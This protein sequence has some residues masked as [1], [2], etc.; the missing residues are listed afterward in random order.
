M[1]TTSNVKVDVGGGTATEIIKALEKNKV[2]SH[3]TLKSIG[4]RDTYG[5][6]THVALKKYTYMEFE[7]IT[8]EHNN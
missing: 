3:A 2:P 8:N 5:T 7:W 6:G 1:I 4:R